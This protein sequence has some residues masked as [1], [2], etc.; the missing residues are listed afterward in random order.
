MRNATRCQNT[1]RRIPHIVTYRAY[2]SIWQW[3]KPQ[4]S[5]VPFQARTGRSPML[6]RPPIAWPREWIIRAGAPSKVRL[7]EG[8]SAPCARFFFHCGGAVASGL[9]TGTIGTFGLSARAKG[10]GSRSLGRYDWR[11]AAY[12]LHPSKRVLLKVNLLRVYLL[13]AFASVYCIRSHC[14]YIALFHFSLLCA[15]LRRLTLMSP[16]AGDG[17]PY[18]PHGPVLL[19][20]SIE[21]CCIFAVVRTS[22]FRIAAVL[23]LRVDAAL[24][25]DHVARYHVAVRQPFRGCY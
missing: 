6:L 5:S 10:S 20:P 18:Q 8:R 21:C 17:D 25:A 23:I 16:A 19:V 1:C 7:L 24:P 11:W 22:L 14:P 12:C 15:T 13:V 9:H 2:R 4:L 3:A